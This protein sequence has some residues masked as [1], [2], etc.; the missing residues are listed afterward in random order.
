MTDYTRADGPP[1]HAL[2]REERLPRGGA[3]GWLGKGVEFHNGKPMTAD[4][5][6]WSIRRMLDKSLSLYATAQLAGL[7]PQNV[8]K[9]DKWTVRLALDTPNSVLPDAF[10][11]YFMGMVPVGYINSKQG[12]PQIGTGP[13]KFVSFTP[14]NRSQFVRNPHY[15]RHG[16]PYFD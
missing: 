11:Q 1:A 8:K 10:G 14:G 4:D 13:Y 15:W 7:R 3:A 6:V 9:V 16:Q 12:G 5:I 2:P